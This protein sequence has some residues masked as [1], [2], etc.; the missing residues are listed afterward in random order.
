MI[1]IRVGPHQKMKRF[2]PFVQL[3]VALAMVPQAFLFGA[4]GTSPLLTDISTG[5][6]GSGLGPQAAYMW[7]MLLASLSVD[8]AAILCVAG[9]M[10]L[11][12]K[13]SRTA[14]RLAFAGAICYEIYVLA[15]LW[16]VSTLPGGLKVEFTALDS[17]DFPIGILAG[18]VAVALRANRRTRAPAAASS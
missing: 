13:P 5:R 14:M 6:F 10:F 2:L 18:V 11:I 4:L 17:F 9:A 12:L 8:A 15:H 16:M 1:R 7:S 3:V